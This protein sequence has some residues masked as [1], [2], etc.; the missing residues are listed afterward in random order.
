MRWRRFRNGVATDIG[1]PRWNGRFDRHGS[2]DRRN[3]FDDRRRL[4]GRLAFA[5]CFI[6]TPQIRHPLQFLELRLIAANRQPLARSGLP[7]GLLELGRSIDIDALPTVMLRDLHQRSDGLR[8]LLPGNDA[9]TVAEDF[10]RWVSAITRPKH[11]HPNFV[12]VFCRDNSNVVS[13]GQI[14]RQLE[15]SLDGFRLHVPSG[16]CNGIIDAHLKTSIELEAT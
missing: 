12:G 3:L 13:I 1:R 6:R 10:D 15:A 16:A 2:H 5:S 14:G 9:I 11:A 8:I 7:N 4:C